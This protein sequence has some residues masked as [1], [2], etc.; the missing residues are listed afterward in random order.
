MANALEPDA[1]KALLD[2]SV[3]PDAPQ[4]H[5]H[6]L[7][8]DEEADAQGH[9]LV[10]LCCHGC[11]ASLTLRLAARLD[12]SEVYLAVRDRFEAEHVD[13]PD[14]GYASACPG[15]RTRFEFRDLEA[16]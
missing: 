12:R 1:L 14:H 4:V 2:V 10:E 6:F 13:C 7:T 9:G 15:F 3:S 8:P 11:G 5:I 16:A